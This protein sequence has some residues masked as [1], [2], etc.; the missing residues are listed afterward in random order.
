MNTLKLKEKQT[1]LSQEQSTLNEYH[2]KRNK[3]GVTEVEQML[4]HPF[5][6]DEKKLQAQK[7][8]MK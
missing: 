1:K 4:K 8:N 2:Q 7:V 5:S 3:E 6:L